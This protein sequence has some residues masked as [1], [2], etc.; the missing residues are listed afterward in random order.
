MDVLQRR[1]QRNGRAAKAPFSTELPN[2]RDTRVS[3]AQIADTLSRFELRTLARKLAAAHWQGESAPA[4][5]TIVTTGFVP[6]LAARVIEAIVAALLAKSQLLPCFLCGLLS[7][8][9]LSFFVFFG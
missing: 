3:L 1:A 9:V 4:A 5:V 6:A 2:R 8:R 7:V